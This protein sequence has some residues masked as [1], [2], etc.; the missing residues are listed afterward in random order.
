MRGRLSAGKSYAEGWK[1]DVP[2]EGF[3]IAKVKQAAGEYKE[4]ELVLTTAPWRLYNAIKLPHQGLLFKLPVD[5][6]LTPE[7]LMASASMPAWTAALSIKH[8]GEPKE[9]QTAF[10]SGAAGAVGLVAGQVLKHLYGVRVIGSAGSD[11]KVELLKSVGY[12]AAFNY[13]T[14]DMDAELAKFAPEGLNIYFDNVGGP[15]MDSALAHMAP[16]GRIIACGAISQY[17]KKPDERYGMKNMFQIIGNQLRIEGFIVT[18]WASEFAETTQQLCKMIKEG[19]LKSKYTTVNGFE[20][21]PSALRGLFSGEN[22]GKYIVA[23]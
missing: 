1:L 17:N 20:N 10:V 8:I 14:A 7:V 9:G 21:V 6:V 11:E 2:G 19:K 5:D 3:L 16:F 18:R 12:D 4:G 13:K 22:T 15:T 23:V